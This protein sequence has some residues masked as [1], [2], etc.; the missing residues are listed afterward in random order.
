M[1]NLDYVTILLS[2]FPFSQNSNRSVSLSATL[3]TDGPEPVTYKEKPVEVEVKFLL[4]DVDNIRR[5]IASTRAIKRGRVFETNFRFDDANDNLAKNASLLRL[6]YD[7]RATLTVKTKPPKADTQFKIHN[8][9][10]VTVSDFDMMRHIL[11]KLGFHRRQTYEKW[12]ET[13]ILNATHLCIDS[14]PFGDFL[15]I[16][17]TKTAIIGVASRL[18]LVWDR[19]ILLN[20]LEMFSIIKQHFRLSFDDVTFDNFASLQHDFRPLVEKMCVKQTS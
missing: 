17:G 12:R 7:D 13:F 3:Y 18:G 19:R 8:E 6:R 20:Y 14:M 4:P 15:E 1:F 11:E 9:Y 5:R 2:F 10:E 16:E